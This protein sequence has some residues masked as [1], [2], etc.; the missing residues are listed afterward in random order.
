MNQTLMTM[1]KG[2]DGAIVNMLDQRMMANIIAA[3]AMPGR[4]NFCMKYLN[5][6][7]SSVFE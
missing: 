3:V 4:D 5:G 2:L 7:R 1:A 6:F